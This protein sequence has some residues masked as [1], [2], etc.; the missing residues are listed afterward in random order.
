MKFTLATAFVSTVLAA[1]Q[2]LPS[3][4]ADH[5]PVSTVVTSPDCRLTLT[6]I[7][8]TTAPARALLL[9]HCPSAPRVPAHD[10]RPLLHHERR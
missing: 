10:P 6:M 5:F 8:P 3:P 1:V 9:P 4:G 2:A 7:P